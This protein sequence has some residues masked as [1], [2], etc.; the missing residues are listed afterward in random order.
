[1]LFNS[2]IT[3]YYYHLIY[4]KTLNNDTIFIKFIKYMFILSMFFQ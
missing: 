1:M 3:D 2:V 4:H